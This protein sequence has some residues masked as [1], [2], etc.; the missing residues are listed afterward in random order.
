MGAERKP[1]ESLK[2]IGRAFGGQ[3]SSI[4]FLVASMVGFRLALRRRSRQG[5]DA[6]GARGDFQRYYGASIGPIDR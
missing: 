3:S 1:G 6:P 2:A 5:I 4:Y